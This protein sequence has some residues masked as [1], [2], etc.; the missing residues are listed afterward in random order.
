MAPCGVRTVPAPPAGVQ[1]MPGPCWGS[2]Q[3]NSL[4]SLALPFPLPLLHPTVSQGSWP[5]WVTQPHPSQRCYNPGQWQGTAWEFRDSVCL[6]GSREPLSPPSRARGLLRD[7]M[8]C[9]KH[10]SSSLEREWG[11]SA[12]LGAKLLPCTA[13]HSRAHRDSLSHSPVKP[14]PEP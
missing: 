10:L 6:G 7:A 2:R 1:T 5:E 9:G 12:G 14:V 3:E 11:L 13:Q 4:S 8:G